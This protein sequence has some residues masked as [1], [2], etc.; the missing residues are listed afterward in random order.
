MS[1]RKSSIDKL[2]YNTS[3]YNL[4]S[5]LNFELTWFKNS[6]V[7]FCHLL[8]V[9]KNLASNV[10]IFYQNQSRK[11]TL[12]V[13]KSYAFHRQTI[14][15]PTTGVL[16]SPNRSTLSEPLTAASAK[17]GRRSALVRLQILVHR[18]T[19]Q[20]GLSSDRRRSR[21]CRQAWNFASTSQKL[22]AC[23]QTERTHGPCR[24]PRRT[25]DLDFSMRRS[26]SWGLRRK[27][28]RNVQTYLTWEASAWTLVQAQASATNHVV[29]S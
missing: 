18:T 24:R 5:E 28:H 21:G 25:S 20:S 17:G 10:I 19:T 16:L 3:R 12:Q 11:K 6:F 29:P 13:I 7:N 22:R 1:S 8:S 9:K 27:S 26:T 4:F 15:C 14:P 2:I 23:R